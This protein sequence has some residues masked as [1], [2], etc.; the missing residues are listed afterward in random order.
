MYAANS[1]AEVARLTQEVG[2]RPDHPR[3]PILEESQRRLAKGPDIATYSVWVK[4]RESLRVNREIDGVTGYL[5]QVLSPSVMWTMTP[6]QLTI[7][8]PEHAPANRDARGNIPGWEKDIGFFRFGGVHLGHRI[9][10]QPDSAIQLTDA[11]Q[12][13]ARARNGLVIEYALQWDPRADRGYFMGGTY[14]AVPENPEAVGTFFRVSGW[15]YFDQADEWFASTIEEFFPDGRP[16][17]T[18]E[19]MEVGTISTEEFQRLVAVPSLNGTDPIR[20]AYT[21][22][23]V[24]DF[25][26]NSRAITTMTADGP[27]SRPMPSGG[28]ADQPT[29]LR[30]AG[31]SVLALLAA[32]LTVLRL[33]PGLVGSVVTSLRKVVKS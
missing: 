29:W 15:K 31:W 20:G 33:R 19:L 17:Q 9:A 26:P 1:P 4:S 5:D 30:A 10:L 14:R 11:W 28:V 2:G 23:S 25:R 32:L 12:I 22:S 8:D 16:N 6:M 27:E 21:F 7:V 13:V 18:L 3:R 24:Y